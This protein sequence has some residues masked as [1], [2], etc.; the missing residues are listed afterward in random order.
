MKKIPVTFLIL[1][2]ILFFSCAKTYTYEP[3]FAFSM[4]LGVLDGEFQS[5]GESIYEY[6]GAS[7]VMDNGIFYVAN[8][9]RIMRFS[10]KGILLDIIT[11]KKMN[12]ELGNIEKLAVGANERIFF[13]NFIESEALPITSISNDLEKGLTQLLMYAN[14]GSTR[15]YG[16]TGQKN[17]DFS[18]INIIE[19]LNNDII[20]VQSVE[21]KRKALYFFEIDGTLLNKTFFPDFFYPEYPLKK[22]NLPLLY[23]TISNVFPSQNLKRLYVQVNYYTYEKDEITD[24][25]L[26]ISLYDTLIFT[27]DLGTGEYS[28]YIALAYKPIENLELELVTAG[29]KLVFFDYSQH[30][31]NGSPL[32]LPRIVVFDRKGNLDT[33]FTLDLPMIDFVDIRYNINKYGYVAAMFFENK[34]VSVYWWKLDALL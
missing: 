3:E 30:K 32:I 27:M 6:H 12:Q 20:A 25:I 15:R 8:G 17:F 9:S 11:S 22:N 14:D 1:I 5:W 13:S 19:V 33:V 4:P 10:S 7:I 34:Q 29:S 21:K 2:P 26:R 16:L 24:S 31:E 18:S 28:E 23:G